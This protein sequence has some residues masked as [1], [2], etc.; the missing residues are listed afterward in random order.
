[1]LLTLLIEIINRYIELK[2]HH[3]FFE[4]L[5]LELQGNL[6]CFALV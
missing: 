3:V 6:Y 1:M 4:P 2:E 5:C